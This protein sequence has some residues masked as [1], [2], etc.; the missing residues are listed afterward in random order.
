M[1]LK[2]NQYNLAKLRMAKPTEID[3]E[4]WNPRQL[5]RGSGA[6]AGTGKKHT[7]FAGSGS[8]MGFWQTRPIT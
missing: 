5:V 2:I 6:G 1:F 8:V 3:G 4:I 7:Y